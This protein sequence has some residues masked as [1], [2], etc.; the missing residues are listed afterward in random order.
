MKALIVYAHPSPGSF[1]S[2]VLQT[3]IAQLQ[4]ANAE[5]RVI[6]LYQEQFQPCLTHEDLGEYEDT[7]CN[8]A[9]I[10]QHVESLRWC[11]TILFVYPTWWFGHPAVLKGWL[12][13]VLVPGV[14]FSMPTQDNPRITHTLHHITRLGVFTTCGA[15]FWLTKMVGSPGKRILMRG[16]RTCLNRRAKS[17]FAAHYLM[18]SSTQESRERHL[19]RV[20]R[21]MQNLLSI[22]AA[23]RSRQIETK[24]LG[25]TA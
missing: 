5:H 19:A 18:D 15:S 24:N 10:A 16:L 23:T 8:T 2:A 12:D 21:K 4:A 17:T 1:N 13:R 7:S 14:A 25:Q 22:K 20:A 9:R 11:N 3:V 6:D